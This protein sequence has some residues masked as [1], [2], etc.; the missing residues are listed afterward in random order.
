MSETS[1]KFRSFTSRGDR[2]FPCPTE[3]IVEKPLEIVINKDRRVLIMCTPGMIRE[4]VFGFLFTEGWIDE[5]DDVGETEI[6]ET[7]GANGEALIEAGVSV[8][9]LKA[10]PAGPGMER[11]SFSSCGI[12]GKEGYSGL[13]KGLVRVKGRR[14]YSMEFL[15][16]LSGKMEE[17]QRLY[18]KTGGSHAAVLFDPEGTPVLYGEDMGRHNALDKVIG[19]SLL[20]GVPREENVLVSSG[21]ASLEMVFKTVRAGVPVFIAMSRPTSRA[22]DAAKAYNLTL[23]D[24]AKG[25]NRIYSHARRIKGF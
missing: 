18:K 14:R 22:V 19:A 21:R 6:L 17:V 11:I 23:I 15:K 5:A 16:S 20:R 7:R 12:C 4:L 2:L 9:T 3:L 24:M 1:R 25:A 8:S 10:G 13:K